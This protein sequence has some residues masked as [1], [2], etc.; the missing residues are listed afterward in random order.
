M[1]WRIRFRQ[2]LRHHPPVLPQAAPG[3]G[4]VVAA[5]V[6]RGDDERPAGAPLLERAAGLGRSWPSIEFSD[7]THS[8]SPS[9]NMRPRTGRWRFPRSVAVAHTRVHHA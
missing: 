1:R 4:G 3:S 9:I 5:T 2:A 6:D 7:L 8:E